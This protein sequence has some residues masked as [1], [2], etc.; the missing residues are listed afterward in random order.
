MATEIKP[1][2][3]KADHKAAL[4]EIERLWDAEDNSPEADRLDVLTTLVEA[5]EAAHYPIDPPN[6]IEAIKFRMEQGGL[7]RADLADMIG[8]RNRV[9]E[10]LNGKRALTVTMIRKLNEGLGIPAEILI[11]PSKKPGRR[12]A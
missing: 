1:I 10:V 8:P 11:R 3:S 9:A 2:R 7:T 12:A 5:Y 6:P 4:T